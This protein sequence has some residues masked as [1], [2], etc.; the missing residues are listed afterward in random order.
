MANNTGAA[1]GAPTDDI[2]I[3]V[4][5]GTDAACSAPTDDI[6]DNVHLCIALS[7]VVRC[8][9]PRNKKGVT[10]WLRLFKSSVVPLLAF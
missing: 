6:G 5:N 2:G 4:A 1:Y 7:A 3:T 10:A 9:A 8:R